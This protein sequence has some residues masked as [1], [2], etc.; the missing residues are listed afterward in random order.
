MKAIGTDVYPE[1]AV[2]DVCAI[3]NGINEA[4]SHL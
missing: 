2:V 1:S 3:S 4:P